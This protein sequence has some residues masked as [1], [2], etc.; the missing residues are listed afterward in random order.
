[1]TSSSAREAASYFRLLHEELKTLTLGLI[2]GLRSVQDLHHRATAAL[3]IDSSVKRQDV[4]RQ[5]D[6]DA[7]S[8]LTSG[9]EA[10]SFSFDSVF[11]HPQHKSSNLGIRSGDQ[12]PATFHPSCFTPLLNGYLIIISVVISSWSLSFN[13]VWDMARAHAVHEGH[14]MKRQ[15]ELQAPLRP[16][17][18]STVASDGTPAPAPADDEDDQETAKM[19]EVWRKKVRR[20]SMTLVKAVTWKPLTE[21]ETAGLEEKLAFKREALAKCEAALREC[22]ERL[23]VSLEES[24]TYRIKMEEFGASL[25]LERLNNHQRMLA[26]S[27]FDG[28]RTT[29]GMRNTNARASSS[30]IGIVTSS[31]ARFGHS[32]SGERKSLMAAVSSIFKF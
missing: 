1:M 6:V 32:P 24:E 18:P 20:G 23:A 16:L 11:S 9:L 21:E 10:L 15:A 13:E 28:D 2:Q 12:Q 22:E 26:S 29:G 27:L 31:S 30:A 7:I 3:P 25:S 5:Q 4:P 14:E 19:E 17:K 8:N